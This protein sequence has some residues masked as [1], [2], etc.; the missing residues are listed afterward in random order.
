MRGLNRFFSRWQNWV[1]VFLLLAY[2]VLAVAAPVL[3]PQD[4]KNPGPF[5]VKGR[6]NE[7]QPQPPSATNLLG[8]LPGQ[9]DVFHTIV[10]GA[11]D[12]LTFSFTVVFFTAFFGVIY[13]AIAGYF[14][15]W[16]NGF[17]MRIADAF[18]AFPVIAGVVFFQQLVIM[19]ISSQGGYYLQGEL[20][21]MEDFAGKPT[22]LQ[23]LFNLVDPLML[24]LILFSWMPYSRM[25]N[26][27]VITQKNTE[28]IQAARALG[29]SPFRVIFRHLIPNSISPVIVLV[30]RDI[31]NVVLFQATLTF[32]HI[33][34]SSPWGELLYMGRN[35]VIGPHGN[36]FRYWWVF[37]PATLA[38]LLFGIGWNLIGDGLTEA[39][40]P[41]TAAYKK[42]SFYKLKQK[43]A[44]VETQALIVQPA[45]QTEL[46]PVV[47]SKRLS[48][49]PVTENDSLLQ[50]AR[51]AIAEQNMDQAMHAYSHLLQHHRY[52][53]EIRHDLVQLARQF[54][55]HAIVWTLLGDAL[56]QEGNREYA[57]KAYEQARNL[58]Q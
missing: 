33:G 47:A 54:P 38:V 31:G 56:T 39:F 23:T 50:V 51:D 16:V 13:G 35:W 32:I 8:T 15:G 4:P 14:G 7:R 24:S 21:G 17:L 37:V 29:A 36:L 41:S 18:L 10:W 44:E 53:G 25:I 2:A 27:M 43:K 26:A 5:L 34:G 20:F 49:S 57:N 46:N 45:I 1:G 22:F 28:F 48:I 3:S 12:A 55:R 6:I 9:V 30:A 52:I 11:G 58:T 40:E 19:T 42:S